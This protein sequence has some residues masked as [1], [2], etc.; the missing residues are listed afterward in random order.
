MKF[1][2]FQL[3]IVLPIF[4]A[5]GCSD[6]KQKENVSSNPFESWYT[7]NFRYIDTPYA[8]YIYRTRTFQDEYEIHEKYKVRFDIDWQ[9]DSTYVLTFDSILANPNSIIFP[10]EIKNFKKTC[11]I[12]QLADSSYLEKAVSSLKMG[13]HFTRIYRYSSSIFH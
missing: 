11:V 2:V 5:S 6:E 12:T 10:S 1:L 9:N 7:G 13:S 8:Y 3:I 4:M